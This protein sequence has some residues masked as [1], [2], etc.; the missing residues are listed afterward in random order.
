MDELFNDVRFALRMIRNTP[1]FAAIA[2]LTLALGIGASTAMFSFVD[3]VMLKP[4]PYP[5]PE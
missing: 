3:G 4:L 2:L 5:H 1:G